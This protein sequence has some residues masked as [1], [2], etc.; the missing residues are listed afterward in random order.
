[1]ELD[2]IVTI[3]LGHG[4]GGDIIVTVDVTEEEYALLVECCREDDEISSYEG[5]EDLYDRIVEEAKDE[6]QS[7]Q[8]E[9][10]DEIDYDDAC[11][12]VDFPD[13]VYEDADLI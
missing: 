13:Q 5:L 1:M 10:E 6:S 7:C 12:R 3:C 4:D 8:P 2:F 11:Y 9:D